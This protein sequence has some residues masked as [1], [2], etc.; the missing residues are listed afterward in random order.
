MLNL[1]RLIKEILEMK[2]F[3]NLFLFVFLLSTVFSFAQTKVYRV[4]SII[5]AWNYKGASTEVFT[6]KKIIFRED[7]DS[8]ADVVIR[9]NKDGKEIT[10]GVNYYYYANS[11][12]LTFEMVTPNK[13]ADKNEEIYWR[14]EFRY[15]GGGQFKLLND[16]REATDVGI[17]E[18]EKP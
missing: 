17:L 4:K 9:M 7:R 14:Y 3:F 1:T 16:K 15:V 10:K 2:R 5:G 12:D 18:H 11:G 6:L 8:V 13:D